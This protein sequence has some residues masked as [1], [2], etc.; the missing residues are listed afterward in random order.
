MLKNFVFLVLSLFYSGL[1]LASSP[2]K[3]TPH[4]FDELMVQVDKWLES[5]IVRQGIQ[6]QNS[7][8]VSLTLEKILEMDE[9]W[10]AEA[11]REDQPIIRTMLRKPLS[12]YLMRM[13]SESKGLFVEVFVMDQRGLN[14]ATAMTTTDLWQGDEPKFEKTYNVGPN[15][16]YVGNPTWDEEFHFWRIQLN[17]SIVDPSSSRAIGAATIEVNLTE[18]LRRQSFKQ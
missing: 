8:Y 18:F 14:V 1:A 15:A 11:E 17:K 6:L 3:L 5:D 9:E 7:K 13:Q 4:A 16:V 12:I 2:P 10:R